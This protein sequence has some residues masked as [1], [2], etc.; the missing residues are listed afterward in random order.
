M[1]VPLIKEHPKM[2]KLPSQTIKEDFQKN[3]LKILLNKLKDLKI[4]IKKSEKEF[5]LKTD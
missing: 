4:K 5:K 1:L 2:P 3:K